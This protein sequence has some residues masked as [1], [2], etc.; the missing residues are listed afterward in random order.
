MREVSNSSQSSAS[1]GSAAPGTYFFGEHVGFECRTANAGTQPGGEVCATR[2]NLP[3]DTPPGAD[4]ISRSYWVVRNYGPNAAFAPLREMRFYR[5]GRV[6]LLT[7]ASDYKLWAR[8]ANGE[9][10][11]WLLED[12]GDHRKF[13]ADG[14]VI[15]ADGL[16]V[17]AFGQF[18]VSKPVPNV[19]QPEAQHRASAAGESAA[20]AHRVF[21]NPAPADGAVVV[22]FDEPGTAVFRL[23]DDKGRAI[24]VEKFEGQAR[25]LLN[26][27]SAG[28]YPYSIEGQRAMVF[29][30]V[31]VQ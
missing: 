27:L 23:F 21:P 12:A 30:R 2:I 13:G 11:T 19:Q 7:A 26:G 24:R 29:G 5:I 14:S 20:V 15:F 17:G 10:N 16:Q 31:V 9:G 22:A 3:P 18:V 28:T 25:I 6:P 1:A 4:P 8:A